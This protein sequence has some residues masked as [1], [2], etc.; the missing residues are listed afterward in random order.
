MADFS[1]NY[2]IE[3]LSPGKLGLNRPA[4]KMPSSLVYGRSSSNTVRDEKKELLPAVRKALS[5]EETQTVVEKI[6]AGRA[7]AESVKKDEA[8]ERRAEAKSGNGAA[9]K[10]QSA[11]ATSKAP[12]AAHGRH[13]D[14]GRP[15]DVAAPRKAE[16][17]TDNAA[18]PKRMLEA[19]ADE[20]GKIPKAAFESAREVADLGAKAAEKG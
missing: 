17:A 3:F 1:R 14:Q 4:E 2:H 6:E 16:E 9:E 19:G 8:R 5:A 11:V 13:N 7:E 20:A 12:E 18:R 10:P 15:P